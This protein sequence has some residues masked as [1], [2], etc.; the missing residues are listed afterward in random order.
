M[1]TLIKQL[2]AKWACSHDWNVHYSAELY[3]DDY[4][5][6]NRKPY[7]IR[8]SLICKKCGKIKKIN[9]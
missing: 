1:I 4:T 6:P 7:G 3:D 8:Q 9:L 5:R 2:F